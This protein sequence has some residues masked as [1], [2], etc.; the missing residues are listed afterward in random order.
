RVPPPG[1]APFKEKVTTTPAMTTTARMPKASRPISSPREPF[2]GG[3]GEYGGYGPCCQPGGG[4]GGC[5]P[6]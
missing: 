2:G 5:Q 1:D 3:Y 6:C 4:P